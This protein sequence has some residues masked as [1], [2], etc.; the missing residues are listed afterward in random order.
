MQPDAGSRQE[1]EQRGRQGQGR[2]RLVYQEREEDDEDQGVVAYSAARGARTRTERE[3][4]CEAVDD[5]AERDGVCTCGPAL[6]GFPPLGCPARRG[7]CRCEDV[8]LLAVGVVWRDHL[9]DEEH[10]RESTEEGQRYYCRWGFKFTA[11]EYSF[12]ASAKTLSVHVHRNTRLGYC[13]VA[14]LTRV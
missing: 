11:G 10:E 13:V 5:E 6:G 7:R 3:P 4:V 8:A 9:F 1:R 2:G 12:G 14:R